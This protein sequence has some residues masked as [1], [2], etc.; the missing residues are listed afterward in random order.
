MIQPKEIVYRSW[1]EFREALVARLGYDL[2][3]KQWDLLSFHLS[4]SAIHPPYSEGDIEYV[5]R[6]LKRIRGFVK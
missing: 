5:R 1:T 6:I 4:A 3:H 2:S